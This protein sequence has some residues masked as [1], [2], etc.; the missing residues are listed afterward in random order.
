MFDSSLKNN[1]IN[2]IPVSIICRFCFSHL[3]DIIWNLK[4]GRLLSAICNSSFFLHRVFF[5]RVPLGVLIVVFRWNIWSRFLNVG[6]VPHIGIRVLHLA[7]FEFNGVVV[8]YPRASNFLIIVYLH[9]LVRVIYRNTSSNVIV[10]ERICQMRV[11]LTPSVNF[12]NS[13]LSNQ[14]VEDVSFDVFGVECL[15]VGFEELKYGIDLL[16]LHDL[17]SLLVHKDVHKHLLDLPD[18]AL[19]VDLL[20]L[21]LD[22]VLND[23]L[24]DVFESDD[25]HDNGLGVFGGGGI[26][27]GNTHD[28]ADVCQSLF[29]VAQKW[30]NAVSFI[31]ADSV[32]DND[33]RQLLECNSVLLRVDQYQIASHQ[34]ANDVVLGAIIDWDA[35]ISF[36]VDLSES[37]LIEPR[38]DVQHVD[39]INFGHDVSSRLLLEIQGSLHN[40]PLILVEHALFLQLLEKVCHHVSRN[41][42]ADLL[43]QNL[44]QN[45]GNRIRYREGHCHEKVYEPG[46]VRAD[47]QGVAGAG[48]LWDYLSEDGDDGC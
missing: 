25:A 42:V 17:I 35:T 15:D 32:P 4:C 19:V 8:G 40:F 26:A 27:F 43:A 20:V 36:A 28:D 10:D 24:D 39:I 41:H 46:S 7:Q 6:N 38:I 45:G 2:L 14:N 11:G 44:V 48:G 23:L 5:A 21:I 13:T 18:L 29:E 31:D 33:T 16:I 34:D 37:L 22:F 47:E 1:W 30:F 12:Q 3:I 9:M